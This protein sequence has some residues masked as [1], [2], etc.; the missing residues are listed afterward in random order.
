MSFLAPL[1]LLGAM[2]VALPVVFHLIRRTTRER[3]VFSSLMFL[4]PTPPRLTRRSRLEHLLLLALRCAVLCLLALGFARPF[5]RHAVNTPPAAVSRRIVLL[6]DTSASMR[7]ADLWAEAR[8]RA[9][10]RL[11]NT[12]PN[13]QVAVFTFDRQV[14]PLI[15][16]EQWNAA[17]PAERATL[18]ERRLE[19]NPPGWSATHLGNALIRAAETLADTGD[20]KTS[21]SGEIVLLS[22]MQEGCRLE[23]LQG[24]EWPKGIE[25]TVEPLKAKH[26]S[27][28]ALQLVTDSNDSDPKAGNAVRVRIANAADAKRE[29][30]KVGWTSADGRAFA[31][32]PTEVYVPPGQSRIVALVIPAG[33]ATNTSRELALP[34]GVQR[35][36]LQGDDEDFDNTVYVIP[37]ETVRL[38]VLY[39]GNESE[40]DARQPLYFLM[41]AFQETRQVAVSVQVHSPALPLLAAQAQAATLLVVSDALPEARAREL[42]EQ[43]AAGKTLLFTLKNSACAATLARMIGV[44]S[45]RLEEAHPANYAMLAEIDFRHPI[46]GPFA[47]P[48]F[49]DFTKIHFWNYRRLDARATPKARVIAKFDNGDPAFLEVPVDKGRVLVLTASWNPE[50]SQLALSTKFVPLL[51]SMLEQSGAPAPTPMQYHVGDQVP[52]PTSNRLDNQIAVDQTVLAPDGAK[53]SIAPGET[54]FSQTLIP[55]IYTFTSTQPARRFAVNLDALESRTTPVPADELERLGAPVSR[56][57]PTA[58]QETKRRIHL[59]NTELEQ[60]QKLW[61]WF[62]V[63]TLVVLLLETGL[64]GM[65]ARR[66]AA[67]PAQVT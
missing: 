5:L 58:V 62:V 54:N 8:A 41:R 38:Q 9:S 44:E 37:P 1:F 33:G 32:K 39:L 36:M 11:R 60:R 18:A 59:Q 3:T 67:P 57:S 6:V 25:L 20:K 64:A 50:D 30:F 13:D 43:V 49:S 2:A 45:L 52:L 34:D 35:I 66:A 42:H 19:E 53:L 47:D 55:G 61:R 27:N 63:A 28:A 14:N 51:Y 7:R 29:Q 16:F 65:T 31:G 10:S 12:S 24:Y 46:F 15:T 21:G 23:P 56:Q 48:R 40:K 22:D 4:L 26:T 17:A